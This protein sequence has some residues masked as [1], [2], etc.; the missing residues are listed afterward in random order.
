MSKVTSVAR[1]SD[2]SNA[3]DARPREH[4]AGAAVLGSVAGLVHPQRRLYL[5]PGRTDRCG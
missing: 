1:L 3:A 4:E 5:V 2:D